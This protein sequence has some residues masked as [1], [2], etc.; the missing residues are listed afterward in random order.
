MSKKNR[1]QQLEQETF[2]AIDHALNKIFELSVLD[3]PALEISEH[4]KNNNVLKEAQGTLATAIELATPNHEIK[5][6]CLGSALYHAT[7]DVVTNLQQFLNQVETLCDFVTENADPKSNVRW[8]SEHVRG[9]HRKMNREVDG[10]IMQRVE[11]YR[12]DINDL[13]KNLVEA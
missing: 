13:K 4:L 5:R 10:E 2:E 8:I 7:D 1:K 11:L 3:D 6:L 12:H 9:E